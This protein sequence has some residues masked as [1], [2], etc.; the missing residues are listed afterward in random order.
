MKKT[1][2]LFLNCLLIGAIYAQ[3][4]VNS[5][6]SAPDPSAMLEVKSSSLGFLPP[7]LSSAQ[8]DQISNPALGLMI[9]NT[10]CLDIQVYNGASWVPVGNTNSSSAIDTIYG[11]SIVCSNAQGEGYEIVPDPNMEEY[12]W[13]VPPGA[14]IDF[15]QGT[16]YI[17]VNFGDTGGDISVY[18][19]TD[20]W[21][22]QSAVFSV[23]LIPLPVAPTAGTHVADLTQITWNW[24]PVDGAAGYKFNTVN[25]SNTA[26]DLGNS[27]SHLETG[28]TCETS[29]KRYVWAYNECLSGNPLIMNISTA[30]CPFSCGT[31]TLTV[32][33]VAGAVAPVNKTVTYSSVTNIPGEPTICW[34]TK[35]LGADYQAASVD[36]DTEPPAGW[37]WQFNRKQGYKHDDNN[38]TPN[39]TWTSSINE[40]SD[41]LASNDPC[42]IELGHNWR[43]PANSEWQNV[44]SA[45]AWHTWTGP[46]NSPLHLHAAG[47]L[48][49]GDGSIFA[50]GINGEYWSSNQ[51]SGDFTSG[52]MMIFYSY[53]SYM[54]TDDKASALTIR[55][56]RD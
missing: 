47:L 31:T 46:W 37:Y 29:Y 16:N 18:G 52:K 48:Y 51:D 55:C 28:L 49:N 54:S 19:Y 12:S 34:I 21:K 25:D 13:S 32:N 40:N 24:N 14:E 1:I 7:R 17:T 41:W 9:F 20:C 56:I 26:I 44:H 39:T 50:R 3:V 35:N 30:D 11:A 45:G 8:R 22:S 27:T 6:Q 38:R 36:D 23:S 15:G 2:L 43:L 33:H 10:D 4:G 5:D 53:N 42:T